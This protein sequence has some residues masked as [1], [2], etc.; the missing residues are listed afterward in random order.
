M[1]RLLGWA[2]V[3]I[4]VGASIM[5]ASLNSSH[6]VTLR[7]GFVTLLGVPLTV[8]VFVAVILGMVVMLGAGVQ[9]DLKVRR[10]LRAR[11]VEEDRE[12]RERA[13][14]QSQQ[15]LFPESD[16]AVIDTGAD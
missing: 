16:G 11:L 3:A 4:L 6:R 1:K 7:L 12:E 14:D 9:S 13:V 15:D 5:F 10:I 8:V 2:S